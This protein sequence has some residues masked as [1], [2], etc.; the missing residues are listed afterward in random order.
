MSSFKKWCPWCD[1]S[2]VMW[3][4]FFVAPATR[5]VTAA[6]WCDLS[7]VLVVCFYFFTTTVCNS[8]LLKRV[9]EICSHV[10]LGM[11]Q[12]LWGSLSRTSLQ[13]L[14]DGQKAGEW[15]NFRRKEQQIS[16]YHWSIRLKRSKE[17][18]TSKRRS[19]IYSDGVLPNIVMFF[20]QRPYG[21]K[22]GVHGGT[23]NSLV[24]DVQMMSESWTVCN[25]ALAINHQW[26]L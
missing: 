6:P 12:S 2:V 25:R 17:T 18:Q 8:V 14:R 16:G 20:L 21:A 22:P 13:S 7:R 3:L 1:F 19:K 9:A 15:L 11:S 4:E 26:L 10:C 23:V 24:A 5:D